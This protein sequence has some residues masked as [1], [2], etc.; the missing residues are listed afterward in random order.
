MGDL[1]KEI[2]IT[3]GAELR[4][5]ETQGMPGNFLRDQ[6]PRVVIK[7]N[8]NVT[9]E[10]L[11][12]EYDLCQGALQI[13]AGSDSSHVEFSYGCGWV[14]GTYPFH[15]SVKSFFGDL[16]TKTI[17]IGFYSKNLK[18]NG[19]II[20]YYVNDA[21]NSFWFLIGPSY[22]LL[23]IDMNTLE[24]LSEFSLSKKPTLFTINPYNNKI[25]LGYEFDPNL[26]VLN[27]DFTPYDEIP[28]SP[29]S[30]RLYIDHYGH[31]QP[32]VFPVKLGFT[33]SGIGL[34]SLSFDNS[35]GNSRFWIIDASENH[36][37]FYTEDETMN[38]ATHEIKSNYNKT[39]L[40]FTTP[41]TQKYFYVFDPLT[42]SFEKISSGRNSSIME[43]VTPS[44]INPNIYFNQH[45]YQGVINMETK[46][47]ASFATTEAP[48]FSKFDFLYGESDENKGL[49]CGE[50]VLELVDFDRGE[51]PTAF[52]VFRTFQ[53]L[54]N[55]IDG[56]FCV[57][58]TH[59]GNGDIWLFQLPIAWVSD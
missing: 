21:D 39:K 3:Q 27:Q 7:F 45:L 40:I 38:W 52:K 34:L 14:G 16:M 10:Q 6:L 18:F 43:Y 41:Y 29:D 25:Y 30:S 12:S 15:I 57:I 4:I 50:G 11:R 47:L 37:L 33:K 36:K 53:I 8:Q 42:A 59:N 56:K 48:D 24:V 35:I 54:T 23:K 51:T 19:G 49:R 44:R 55:T 32:E 22:K 26:Y 17:D 28:I 1:Q 2:H 20:S 31:L 46:V 13:I 5:I 9:V 58:A